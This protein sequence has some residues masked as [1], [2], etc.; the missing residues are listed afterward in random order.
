MSSGGLLNAPLT[1]GA[2]QIGAI[3]AG[4]MA[5]GIYTT[6][7]AE[8]CQYIAQHSEAKVV[9]C[10]GIPQAQKFIEVQESLPELKA[11]VVYNH[12]GA[13]PEDVRSAC[14]VDIMTFA[15]FQELGREVPDERV[16]ERSSAQQNNCCTVIYTSGTT[17]PPKAVMISHDNITWVTRRFINMVE[18]T[19]DEVLVSYLP[20]SHIAAQLLDIHFPMLI[21]CCVHFAR[22]DALRGSL[23]QTLQAARPTM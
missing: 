14:K 20:L 15:Q 22:P 5:A 18:L 17:G 23:V 19:A 7:A 9:V 4:G 2:S 12:N 10:E 11:L 3:F 13:I 1:L 6:N 21:G 16:E 8:A